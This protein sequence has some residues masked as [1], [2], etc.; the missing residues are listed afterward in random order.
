[1]TI[2]MA[3]RLF[4]LRKSHNLSQEEL[5]EKL[6]VSRQAVSK[7][8]RCEAS[9][10]TDNLIGLAK[11]YELSLDELIFGEKNQKEESDK[12][13][14]ETAENSGNNSSN[15]HTNDANKRVEIG[16]TSIIVEDEDGETVTIGLSGIKIKR[17]KIR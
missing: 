4:E 15:N 17:K 11:I 8:E 9:P 3:N 7:W 5:A 12:K 13:D 2:E 6:N 14:S 16:P 1:M 10:D